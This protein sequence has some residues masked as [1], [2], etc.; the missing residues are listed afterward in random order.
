[1]PVSTN[2]SSGP[3]ARVVLLG[4]S[5]LTLGLR[6]VLQTCRSVLRS[7]LE[8][9]GALGHGRSYGMRSTVI[10]RSLPGIHECGLWE[11]LE[12]DSAEPTFA[13]LTDVGN[14]VG[15]EVVVDRIEEWVGGALQR[16]SRLNAQTV[17]TLLPLASLRRLSAL[18]YY[19]ARSIFFPR[20]RLGYEEARSR[21]EE[22]DVRLRALAVQFGVGTVEPE[23]RWYG[24]DPI[25][26]R[27]RLWPEVWRSIL[28]T[29]HGEHVAEEEDSCS[30]P[31]PSWVGMQLLRPRVRW[32]FG[33]QQL[34]AQ[35]VLTLDD[36]TTL[37]LY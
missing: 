12:Q 30:G 17:M 18:Q 5:N 20:S 13:L 14:D 19:L 11:A 32:L 3:R 21:T 7:P 10:A 35:P 34:T 37:S 15:Y 4:A 16:L 2:P 29:W 9:Y 22:L 31:L 23:A 33:R 28:G 6:T 24:I 8:I 25:H 26:V 27:R 1:M 36:G